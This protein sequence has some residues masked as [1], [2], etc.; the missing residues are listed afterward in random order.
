[1]GYSI[2]AAIGARISSSLEIQ[3]TVICGDGAFLMLGLEAHTA[4]E[5]GSPILFVVFNNNKHGMCVTRQQLFFEGR[6]EATEYNKIDIQRLSR[7]LASPDQ[8]WSQSASTADELRKALHDFGHQ[9][10]KKPGLLE[11]HLPLEE[12]PPFSPFLPKEAKPTWPPIKKR[13][14]DPTTN[15]RNIMIPITIKL[16]SLLPWLFFGLREIFRMALDLILRRGPREGQLATYVEQQN[17]KAGDIDD[18]L[19]VI[20]IFAKRRFLMNVGIEKGKILDD[21]MQNA[22][23]KWVLEMGCYCGYSAVRI[24]RFLKE[25]GGKLIS[26]EKSE[27]FASYASRVIAH[28]GLSEYVE[29]RVGSAEE[30]IPALSMRSLTWYSLTTGKTATSRIS[31]RSRLRT[32]W[33]GATVIADNVGIFENTLVPYLDYVRSSGNYTSI[34]HK[35]P[36]EYFK[37]IDDGVEVSI[38]QGSTRKLAA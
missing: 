38:W 14:P 27:A 5:L 36:M 19:R 32:S 35:A 16:K 9:T 34:H 31:K 13:P 7:G 10:V 23:A 4:V 21:A 1:M 33:L 20:D 18:V 22:Q 11:L 26:L 28:A 30:Q 12:L 15:R 2:A 17:A 6:T 3:T 8:M 25:T 29:I 37:A 24:G